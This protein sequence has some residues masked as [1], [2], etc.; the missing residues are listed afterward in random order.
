MMDQRGGG[1]FTLDSVCT[2]GQLKC[3]LSERCRLYMLWIPP[4]VN[5]SPFSVATEEFN[6]VN[7][8]EKHGAEY[9]VMVTC[10]ESTT[11]YRQA[12]KFSGMEY[13]NRGHVTYVTLWLSS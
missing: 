9:T 13:K 2:I 3:E 7:F 12:R 10:I 6:V 11:L 1:G 8:G 4:L 5:N